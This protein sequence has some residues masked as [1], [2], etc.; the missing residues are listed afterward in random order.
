MSEAH[1]AS[2]HDAIPPP[3]H[4]RRL[5]YSVQDNPMHKHDGP[6]HSAGQEDS[7]KYVDTEELKNLFSGRFKK[8]IAADNLI[9][10]TLACFFA[11][12]EITAAAAAI[13]AGSSSSST[14]RSFVKMADSFCCSSLFAITIQLVLLYCIWSE[15]PTLNNDPSFCRINGDTSSLYMQVF[16]IILF[17]LNT[18]YAWHEWVGNF[19]LCRVVFSAWVERLPLQIAV[20]PKTDSKGTVKV[21]TRPIDKG[22]SKFNPFRSPCTLIRAVLFAPLTFLEFIVIIVYLVVGC[23]YLLVQDSAANLTQ[24]AVS[25]TLINQVD[26]VINETLI[27]KFIRDGVQRINFLQ[28]KPKDTIEREG[29]R[30]VFDLYMDLHFVPRGQVRAVYLWLG[31]SQVFFAALVIV[32][33]LYFNY[34][35]TTP[36]GVPTGQPTGQPTFLPTRH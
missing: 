10:V 9:G 16:G 15:L 33:A 5:S 12:P 8:A 7:D 21:D 29:K 24:A 20:M 18:L 1:R 4:P 22:C 14:H 11:G 26:N 6:E 28:D 25:L 17:F 36:S 2:D 32:A 3:L 30:D 19:G 27:P 23:R 31:L 13:A 35:D 34:C